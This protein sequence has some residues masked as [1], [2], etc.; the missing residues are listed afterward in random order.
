MSYCKHLYSAVYAF[1]FYKQLQLNSKQV[2]YF[3]ATTIP[4]IF[5][6]KKRNLFFLSRLFG[7][8]DAKQLIILHMALT[9]K[10]YTFLYVNG[11]AQTILATKTVDYGV[12]QTIRSI[13]TDLCYEVVALV[14]CVEFLRKR[15][16]I[17]L[18]QLV[19]VLLCVVFLWCYR[20]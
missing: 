3:Y 14:A 15:I 2:I 12:A 17:Y 20:F 10:K 5:C 8:I 16:V 19:S 11:P 13:D 6:H 4:P 9:G 1:V 18:L 7:L